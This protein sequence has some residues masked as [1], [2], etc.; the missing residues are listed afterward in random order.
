MTG[1]VSPFNLLSGILFILN[2]LWSCIRIHEQTVN[3]CIAEWLADFLKL[4]V[5]TRCNIGVI[6][7]KAF[8]C[9]LNLFSA[10]DAKLYAKLQLLHQLLKP[11]SIRWILTAGA[12]FWLK[13]QS[14]AQAGLL[15]LFSLLGLKFNYLLSLLW[16]LYQTENMSEFQIGMFVSWRN[17]TTQSPSFVPGWSFSSHSPHRNSSTID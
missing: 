13:C 10:Q 5:L 4:N 7:C 3:L 1:K 8:H 11:S 2:I 14:D 6:I 12:T 17:G 15:W 16:S 9:K